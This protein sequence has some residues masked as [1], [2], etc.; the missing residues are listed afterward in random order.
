MR[1]GAAFWVERTRWP[2]VREACLAA[3]EAGFDS[4]W[5]DDHLLSDEGEWRSPKLE[6]WSVLAALAAVTAR[7]RLG[8][9]VGAN[10]F[11]GPGLVAKLAATLDH[12]SAGRAILGL[13]GG[14]FEREHEAFGIDFGT[15]FGERLD[16]L[17][18][19][20]SI[21]RRLLDGERVT[22]HG[23]FYR[24][25]EAV[26]EPRP[27]QDRLPILI[28]GSGPRKTL[29]TTARHADLWNGYGDPARIAAVSE[30]LRLRCAEVGRPFEMIERT[31]TM[32]V[33]IRDD[34]PAARREWADVVRRHGLYRL[35]ADDPE[36]QLSAGG[37]PADVAAR[38]AAFERIGIAEVMWIFRDPFDLATI[39][40]LPDVRAALA[41]LDGGPAGSA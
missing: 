39:R 12:I 18:E 4:L 5:I 8:L 37:P 29:A 10:T 36:R 27:V 40:R 3:E 20:V 24:L 17:D 14:W 23:R 1:I 11:R 28:G 19:A 7:P 34:E 35:D 22:H 26:C 16:R 15:G 31:V 6:G 33:L 9:L 32:D 13:G 21:I 41:S 38:V 25:E 2:A 30:T